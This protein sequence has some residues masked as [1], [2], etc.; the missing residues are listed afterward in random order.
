MF[1]APLYLHVDSIHISKFMMIT[2]NILF[3]F[4]LQLFTAFFSLTGP[5]PYHHAMVAVLVLVE[6]E[7][8]CL[9]HIVIKQFISD[10]HH[11]VYFYNIF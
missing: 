3:I 11:H 10:L 6:H 4:A 1:S 2:R 7:L 5:P 9:C 8:A